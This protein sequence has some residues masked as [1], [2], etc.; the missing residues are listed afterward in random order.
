MASSKRK[1]RATRKEMIERKRAE[2]EKLLAQEEG[3]YQEDT[4]SDS[5]QVKMMRK[6]LRRR[7]TLLNHAQVA[8]D[9]KPATAKTPALSTIYDKIARLEERLQDA[10]QTRDNAEL[11]VARL[12]FDIENLEKAL[13][14]YD[15][16]EVEEVV[17]P[18]LSFPTDADPTEHDAEV[19]AS[20]DED[21]D[22]S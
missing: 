15:A 12:P 1:P 5:F 17:W 19:A 13:A 9:G 10:Y 20:I 18:E 2:L 6:A 11:A 14:D 16:G 21:S 8:I 22:D 3:S 7:N 4:S